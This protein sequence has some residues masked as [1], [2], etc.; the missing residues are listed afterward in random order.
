MSCDMLEPGSWPF[1]LLWQKRQRRVLRTMCLW[2]KYIENAPKDLTK[3]TRVDRKRSQPLGPKTSANQHFL[4]CT[5]RAVHCRPSSLMFSE[6]SNIILTW[7]F[8]VSSDTK[9]KMAQEL[10]KHGQCHVICWNLAFGPSDLSVRGDRE[11]Y[12]APLDS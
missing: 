8:P 4:L 6:T 3:V 9:G 5:S 2:S 10:R 12:F 1:G 11:D 7:V